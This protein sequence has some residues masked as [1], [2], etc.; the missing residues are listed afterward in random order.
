LLFVFTYRLVLIVVDKKCPILGGFGKWEGVVARERRCGTS[1]RQKGSK[2]HVVVLAS[3][4]NYRTFVRIE[5]L[6]LKHGNLVRE[7]PAAA[8]REDQNTNISN[9]PPIVVL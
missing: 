5:A 7:N 8:F 1:S 9:L 3:E 6:R 2:S 4:L